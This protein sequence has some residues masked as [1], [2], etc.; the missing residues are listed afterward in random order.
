MAI[1]RMP[2]AR[3]LFLLAIGLFAGRNAFAGVVAESTRVVFM[4]GAGERSLQLI[5]LNDYP[6]VVEAWVDDGELDSLPE[7][8]RAPILPLP[9]IFRMDPHGQI[10]LR[11]LYSGAPLPKDRES[12]FWLNLYEIPPTELDRSLDTATLT[13]AIR[14]QMKVFVRPQG[15]SASSSEVAAKLEFLLD[16]EPG[17]PH[18]TVKNPTP[19]FANLA[20]LQ[21]THAAEEVAEA[22]TVAPHGDADV[23]IKPEDAARTEATA[24][25]TLIDD[26]GNTDV[27]ARA[28]RIVPR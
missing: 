28:C 22:L 8:S 1:L 17:R 6:V 14:T 2:F 5:N 7:N 18:L 12:L 10:S 3:I 9:P 15:L 27:R 25:F 26:D 20:K 21:F 16:D 23:D 13:V 24:A 19:Y 4:A 11:L